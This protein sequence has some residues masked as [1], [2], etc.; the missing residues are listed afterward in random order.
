MF[1]FSHKMFV[2]LPETVEKTI[3]SKLQIK[4]IINKYNENLSHSLTKTACEIKKNDII[5][6]LTENT[7]ILNRLNH[8]EYTID[9]LTKQRIYI[10]DK[11]NKYLNKINHNEL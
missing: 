10:Y 9:E 2:E 3:M 7:I 6:Q 11:Y 4:N 1:R 8:V 5:N